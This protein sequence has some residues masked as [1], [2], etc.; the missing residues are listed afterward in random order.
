MVRERRGEGSSDFV[1]MAM[2]S[3]EIYQVDYFQERD[4]GLPLPQAF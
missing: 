2:V 1:G 3:S 4:L